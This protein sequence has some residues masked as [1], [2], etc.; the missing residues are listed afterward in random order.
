[1]GTAKLRGYNT[2]CILQRR[3]PRSDTD[4]SKRVLIA[5]EDGVA[6]IKAKRGDSTEGADD[7][8]EPYTITIPQMMDDYK[9]RV[10]QSHCK[11]PTGH[12]N[13]CSHRQL[14]F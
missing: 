3:D 2:S 11:L 14:A 13:I 9:A 8:G 7:D 10:L 6:K 1:M 4:G 12:L 5:Y